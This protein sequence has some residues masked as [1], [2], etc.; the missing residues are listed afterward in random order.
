MN[1]IGFYNLPWENCKR[2]KEQQSNLFP[3]FSLYGSAQQS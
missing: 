3:K 1:Q 2:P